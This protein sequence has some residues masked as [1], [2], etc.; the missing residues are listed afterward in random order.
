MPPR[1]RGGGRERDGLTGGLGQVPDVG[2]TPGVTP[3]LILARLISAVAAGF[4]PVPGGE[5]LDALF[6][7]VDL[8]PGCTPR[9]V[10][11]D[12]S[13]VRY[14]GGDQQDV[15]PGLAVQAGGCAQ[16]PSPVPR[17]ADL[18]GRLM[19][20]AAQCGDPLLT[21]RVLAGPGRGS[22]LAVP[23]H[24]HAPLA[25]ISGSLS[26][27]ASRPLTAASQRSRLFATL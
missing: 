11:L 18:P 23:G 15:R 17:G 24:H 20:A 10:S 5:D 16:V 13:R 22:W 19:Q 6:I 9:F 25:R 7:P 12:Q 26:W 4:L 3:A 14:P 8:A 1:R 21:I 27:P 2:D